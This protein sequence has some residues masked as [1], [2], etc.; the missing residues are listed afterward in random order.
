M[1]LLRIVVGRGRHRMTGFTLVELL[2][3]IA[4]IGTLVGLLLPAVQS[5]REA[6]RMSACQN[7]L[8][9]IGL[10]CLNC[11]DTKGSLPPAHGRF[12]QTS[13]PPPSVD[14]YYCNTAMFWLLPFIEEERVYARAMTTSGSAAGWYSSYT[15]SAE[16]YRIA[17]YICPSDISIDGAGRLMPP[18]SATATGQGAASYAANAQAFTRTNSNG[19]IADY[20]FLNR[21]PK[22]FQDGTAKTVLYAEKIGQCNGVSAGSGTIWSRKNLQSSG[23]SPHFTNQLYGS[24]YGIQSPVRDFNACDHRLPST[25]HAALNLVLADGSVR[26]VAGS[27]ATSV[28]WSALTPSGSDGPTGDW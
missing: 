3:V 27:I 13:A 26:A 5:A 23:L 8:K 17:P 18:G 19:S 7:N 22:N 15:G 6:A 1:A 14:T 12:Q 16:S 10:A 24:S 11:N 25:Y 2:V 9:Q 28:W 20:E 21:I 4:I